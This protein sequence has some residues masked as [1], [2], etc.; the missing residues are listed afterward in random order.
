MYGLPQAGILAQELLT[1]RQLQAGYT[2]STI[3][4]GF[5]RHQWWPISFTLV[6]NNFGVK[7]IN[8]A[9]AKHLLAVLKNDY[10]CDTDWDG[11]RYLGLTLN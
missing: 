8:K 6:V 11:T 10:E 5:W 2:K 7:Y 3:T 1:E 9:D 4:P